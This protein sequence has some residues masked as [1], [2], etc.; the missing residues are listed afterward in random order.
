[1]AARVE[2]RPGAEKGLVGIYGLDLYSL[3]ASMEA[4]LGYL[5]KVDPQKARRARR[6][7]SCFEHF[8]KDHKLMAP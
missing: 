3:H 2:Q 7:Y 4:V 5:D 8:R 1:M 6:R